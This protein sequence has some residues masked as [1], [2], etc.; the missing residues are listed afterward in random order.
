MAAFAVNDNI[1]VHKIGQYLHDINQAPTQ[2]DRLVIV[3]QMYRYLVTF[4]GY[5]FVHK[6]DNFRGAAQRKLTEF[7]EYLKYMENN[8]PLHQEMI[9]YYNEL[10]D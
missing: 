1:V 7:I 6:H 9:L 4:E 5:H 3:S 2:N 8:D 10:F